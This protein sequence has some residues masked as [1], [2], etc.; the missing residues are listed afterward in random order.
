MSKSNQ[1]CRSKYPF[2]YECGKCHD[3]RKKIK[4]SLLWKK[5][6]KA[7]KAFGTKAN[8][9]VERDWL[10]GEDFVTVYKVHLNAP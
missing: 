2:C 9:E 4:R 1:P 10:C 5:M 8:A 3:F 7:K 6:H